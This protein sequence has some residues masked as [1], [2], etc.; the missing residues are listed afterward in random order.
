M[1]GSTGGLYSGKNGNPHIYETPVSITREK[2]MVP[3][4]YESD[5]S[6]NS[7]CSRR[8]KLLSLPLATS[9]G[10]G[11]KAEAAGHQKAEKQDLEGKAGQI[12]GRAG[13]R[14]PQL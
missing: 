3:S 9:C 14:S 13:K 5:I 2:L 7:G 10:P 1:I 12:A 6:P 8:S 11:M 4:S